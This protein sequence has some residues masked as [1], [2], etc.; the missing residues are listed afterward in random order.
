MPTNAAFVSQIVPNPMETGKPYTVEIQMKNTGTDT[1]SQAGTY[2]LGSQNPP[3]NKIW[4]DERMSLID[5]NPVAPGATGT[6]RK[7]F[8]APGIGKPNFQWRLVRD[9]TVPN[10]GGWFGATTPNVVV[11]VTAVVTPPDPI[12]T[13]GAAIT[14]DIKGTMNMT[15]VGNP[16]GPVTS[17]TWK[18]AP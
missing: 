17:V 9:L 8:N 16:N 13:V 5:A 6:F 12:P 11:D 2:R 10:G 18:V 14:F 4:G 1:W 15:V 7:T 3:D